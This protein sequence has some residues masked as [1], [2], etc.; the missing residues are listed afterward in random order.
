MDGL[1]S[2]SKSKLNVWHIVAVLFLAPVC[3]AQST[4]PHDSHQAARLLSPAPTY[5]LRSRMPVGGKYTSRLAGPALI[6]PERPIEEERF[7]WSGLILQSIAFDSLQNG[8]RTIT[9]SQH[10]RHL[11]LN[12]PFWSD[13]RA[14][15]AEFNWRRWNDGDSIKVNY[16]GHPMEGAVAGYIEIQNNPRDRALRMSN[17]ADYWHSRL[18]S[19][20][21]SAVYSTQWEL[22]PLGESAI[23]NQG[24][25]T[26]PTRCKKQAC[27]SSSTYT[28]NTGW[29]DLVVTPVIGTMWLIGEDALDKLITDPLVHRH[30]HQFGFLVLRSG[31]NPSRS[32]ANMLRGKY[33][34]YRDYEHL[35]PYGVQ[36][37]HKLSDEEDRG[38]TRHAD[39]FLFF[40]QAS[41]PNT[42]G[43]GPVV[44]ESSVGGGLRIAVKAMKYLDLTAS[45]SGF[46]IADGS[47]T[48][49]D[50]KV[51]QDY[52]FGIRSGI[53]GKPYSVHVG[54]APGMVSA[55]QSVDVATPGSTTGSASHAWNFQWVGSV[56]GDIKIG[57]RLG[58]RVAVE[59]TVIRYRSAVHDPPGVGTP[60]HLSFLSHDNYVNSTAWGIKAGPVIFF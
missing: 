51:I 41:F 20:A 37:I 18:R 10:D 45:V 30:P 14:S 56:E 48:I 46:P 32:L 42:S 27:D 1:P 23:F 39:V 44:R 43:Q 24:G 17:T 49:G 33:P 5:S 54:L 47:K 9:A 19:F 53:E 7:H 50:V 4:S 15:L 12:K 26:Y 58:A 59:D 36:S 31:A 3:V 11:L 60:P 25:F 55:L 22:G 8:V 35:A 21:W 16:I 29:V 34:W 13:Y 28:N 38:P 52:T 40:N 2:G 6:P 57:R